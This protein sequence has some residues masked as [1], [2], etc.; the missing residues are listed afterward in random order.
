MFRDFSKPVTPLG[1][2]FILDDVSAGPQ[3]QPPAA[4]GIA[5]QLRP[6]G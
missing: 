2:K 5:P 3:A 1:Y 4:G 6:G